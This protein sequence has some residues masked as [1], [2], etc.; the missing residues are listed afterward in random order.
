MCVCVCIYVYI[1]VHLEPLWKS[2]LTRLDTCFLNI[3]HMGM[4]QCSYPKTTL[5]AWDG[6]HLKLG[7]P[8]VFVEE[9]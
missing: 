6:V 9:K 4:A 5:K 7:D 8:E 3:P 2:V 1:H